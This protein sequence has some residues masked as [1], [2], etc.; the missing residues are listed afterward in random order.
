MPIN[1][2]RAPRKGQV[3][4]ISATSK[5]ELT[6]FPLPMGN[7]N[8]QTFAIGESH[9]EYDHKNNNIPFMDSQPLVTLSLQL[10]AGGYPKLISMFADSGA[11]CSCATP[12][13]ADFLRKLGVHVVVLDSENPTELTGYS[14]ATTYGSARKIMQVHVVLSPSAILE[15]RF[16]ILGAI[17]DPAKILLGNSFL[18]VAKAVMNFGTDVMSFNING[19]DYHTPLIMGDPSCLRPT[20]EQAVASILLSPDNTLSPDEALAAAESYGWLKI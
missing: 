15:L 5:A 17:N 4:A 6:V 20:R 12:A 9:S 2:T 13:T 18:R 11:T 3:S 19:M 16:G 7:W 14:A 1:A 8:G 10:S